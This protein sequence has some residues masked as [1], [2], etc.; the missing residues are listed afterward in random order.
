MTNPPLASKPLTQA[1][2]QEKFAF[3]KATFGD[4]TFLTLHGTLDH[5]FEGRKIAESIHTKKL[6][7]NLRDVRRFASWGMS[8]WMDFLRIN[9]SRELYLV[10]CS[11]YSMSQ[12]NIVT[13]LLGHAR[14]VSFYASYRCGSCSEEHENLFLIPRDRETIRDLPNSQKECTTCGGRTRL[15]DYPAAFF[16]T[17]SD[18]PLFDIDDEVLAFFRAQFQYPLTPDLSRFRAYR[19]VHKGYSYLRLSGNI[20]SLP[21][22]L[23]ATATEGTAVVDL[24][25]IVFDPAEVTQWR[26]YV[27]K[28]LPKVKSLQLLNCPLGFIE[29]AVVLEDLRNKLKVRTFAIPYDCMLCETTTPYM[30]DVAE[31]L[32]QLVGGIAP[33]VICPTCRSS[34]VAR[35]LPEQVTFMRYLPARDRDVVLDKFLITAH[36]EPTKKLENCLVPLASKMPK[37][38][39][40]ARRM[41]YAALGLAV[42]ISGGLAVVAVG[43]WKQNSE[44]PALV[45][46]QAA[47]I[48]PRPP[49]PAF[50]RPA[51]IM[52]DVPSSAYCHDMI[53]RLMCV[54]VSSY[55]PTRDEAVAEANDAAL[56]ELVSVIGLKI[57]E[58]F[59]REN[60]I[61]G[62]SDVRAKALSALQADL[63]Q[64]SAAYIAADDVVTKA[65]KRVVEALRISGGPAV[66][67]QRADWYWEEYAAKKGGTEALVFVRYDVTLDAVKALVEKYSAT[68]QVL[69]SSVMTA[70]PAVAWQYADFTGG[71]ML[72]KVGHPLADINLAPRDL[73]MAV[74]DQR[75]GEMTNFARRLDE[76]K[77]GSE[78]LKLMVK[79]GDMPARAVEVPRQRAK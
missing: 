3:E 15:E 69:G 23:L 54:G 6:V 70:F 78:D 79:T 41:M 12:I 47:A 13:G 22:D 60:V 51:W 42:L 28:S 34:L 56:E 5:A 33:A 27:Q 64:T 25:G 29:N 32:E 66:P 71:V 10:E 35:L 43:L 26:A 4:I 68:T 50:E 55:R 37:A 45:N 48:P 9:A 46:P 44:P 1:R 58:P 77:Q 72:T 57:S 67:A 14:L 40:A 52:S 65:R 38:P 31:N 61:A 21:S 73:V 19:R 7:V 20:A 53:N 76:W 75:I 2:S 11:T 17:I 59:F 39:A 30:I 63:D 8:E 74:A 49:S 36:A 16:D 62:Y 18:R 24:E